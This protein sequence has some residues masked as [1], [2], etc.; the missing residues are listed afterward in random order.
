MPMRSD[1]VPTD[2]LHIRDAAAL[3]AKSV[4][5][6]RRWRGQHGLRD[7]RDTRA[8]SCP[9]LFSRS[10]LMDLIARL[11]APLDLAVI[12][13]VLAGSAGGV[14]RPVTTSPGGAIVHVMVE[15]RIGRIG[16]LFGSGPAEQLART[17]A[18][19]HRTP[20][21]WGSNGRNLPLRTRWC[22]RRTNR[23]R[24]RMRFRLQGTAQA[25]QAAP[26]PA[27]SGAVRPVTRG[28]RGSSSPHRAPRCRR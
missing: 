6:I 28:A 10:D 14:P 5:T 4:D 24:R 3:A 16:P 25:S 2:L 8:P 9:S 13:G 20:V 19:A 17:P 26:G 27:G 22:R 15:E 23:R 11:S 12:D 21:W 7:Y 1:P 18:D